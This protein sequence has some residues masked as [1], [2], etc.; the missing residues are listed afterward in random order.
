M[1]R[2]LRFG[3][4]MAEACATEQMGHLLAFL[5]PRMGAEMMNG[6]AYYQIA[7][8]P[9]REE[10]VA[11]LW[12]DDMMWG[13]ISQECGEVVLELYED[14]EG[15]PWRFPLKTVERLLRRARRDLLNLPLAS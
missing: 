3:P 12:T 14:E 15:P 5:N 2:L 1:D 10:L 6:E 9:D 4:V 7:S 11:E 8:I 13:E